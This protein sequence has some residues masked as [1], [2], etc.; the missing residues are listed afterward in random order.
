MY[1]RRPI[2]TQYVKWVG[3]LIPRP[4]EYHNGL[5]VV[6]SNLAPFSAVHLG[7]LPSKHIRYS[8]LNFEPSTK[9]AYIE[10]L[11]QVEVTL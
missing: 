3:S 7:S 4:Y 1:V 8:G 2:P 10:P 6:P 5:N 9:G 11:T